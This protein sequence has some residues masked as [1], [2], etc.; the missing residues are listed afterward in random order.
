VLSL[1]GQICCEQQLSGGSSGGGGG[2]GGE[3][4]EAC[5]R[6][7]RCVSGVAAAA[8][9]HDSVLILRLDG[10]LLE[11]RPDQLR[12]DAL[13]PGDSLAAKVEPMG[14]AATVI[15]PPAFVRRMQLTE[16]ESFEAPTPTPRA[17]V[18]AP[19]EWDTSAI[20]PMSDPL[21]L[22]LVAPLVPAAERVVHAAA[23]LRHCA[24]VTADGHAH[25]WGDSRWEQA[26]PVDVGLRVGMRPCPEMARVACGA[27][28]SVFVSRAGDVYTLGRG[29]HGAL[30]RLPPSVG[31]ANAAASAADVPRGLWS[32]SRVRLDD[33]VRWVDVTS[34][35]AH[36]IAKGIGADG[37]IQFVGW[38]RCDLGQW[39][40]GAARA[41]D[42]DAAGNVLVPLPLAPPPDIDFTCDVRQAEAQ[43]Q[44]LPHA[45]WLEV[46][47][48]AE[49]TVACDSRGLLWSTGWDSHG[50]LGQGLGQ[51]QGQGGDQRMDL[52]AAAPLP[53]PQDPCGA[54]RGGQWRAIVD[55]AGR[56]VQMHLVEGIPRRGWL[57]CGGGHCLLIN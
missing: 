30:G 26:G 31:E 23:G 2:G 29:K 44:P 37:S 36:C 46:W 49:H 6:R 50:V 10:G 4:E 20:K 35:W 16:A 27:R 41:G 19:G 39:A 43:P 17:G 52:P 57:S 53:L 33:K 38:G 47:C 18:G 54:P 13:R 28:H 48:G 55:A 3:G 11:V 7:R 12:T 45:T 15:P 1:S 9:G 21:S 14:A 5:E 34:G 24:C 8:M 56:Q 32:D 22:A 51:G 42:L 25:L 40:H